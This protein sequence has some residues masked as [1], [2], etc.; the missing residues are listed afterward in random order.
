MQKFRVLFV[1]VRFSMFLT[2][3]V[4]PGACYVRS[5]EAIGSTGTQL[6]YPLA[7]AVLPSA[8]DLRQ[9]LEGEWAQTL[10]GEVWD[11]A[12]LVVGG[13]RDGQLVATNLGAIYSLLSG[14]YMRLMYRPER[15]I[16][17]YLLEEY[18]D[19]AERDAETA[20]DMLVNIPN[21]V[22]TDTSV[23]P[24][25]FD[26]LYYDAD[27]QWSPVHTIAARIWAQARLDFNRTLYGEYT[28][29]LITETEYSGLECIMRLAGRDIGPLQ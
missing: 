1:D 13:S 15:E 28:A 21:D 18:P 2:L 14:I 9:L 17:K 4:R 22:L 8:A 25:E 26:P 11:S 16:E 29:Q 12:E 5:D 27:G 19:L 24:D 7:G 3:V 10:M 20:A 6:A 23:E